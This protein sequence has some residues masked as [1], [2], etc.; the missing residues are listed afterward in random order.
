MQPERYSP[1]QRSRNSV[2]LLTLY[3]ADVPHPPG[4][5]TS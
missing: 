5:N 4:L 2:F 3:D 1:E